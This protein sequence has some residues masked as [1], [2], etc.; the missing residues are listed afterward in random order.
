MEE[1]KSVAVATTNFL[2]RMKM[3]A[4]GYPGYKEVVI[5]TNRHVYDGEEGEGNENNNSEVNLEGDVMSVAVARKGSET[6]DS[7]TSSKER[8][9]RFEF[10]GKFYNTYMEK[11]NAKRKYNAEQVA[12]VTMKKKF[13]GFI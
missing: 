6:D 3:R 11:V 4:M 7:D 8:P 12:M 2:Y 1:R 10:N 5:E 13:T 9:R